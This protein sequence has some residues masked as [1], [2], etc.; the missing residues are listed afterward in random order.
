GVLG[1]GATTPFRKALEQF[2][3][4]V[5]F[6]ARVS[7]LVQLL[8]KLTSPGVPDIYQGT[9][10]WDYSLVDPDN[11]RPVDYELR[12][13][14][15]EEMNEQLAKHGQNPGAVIAALLEA[16]ADG[17]I[18]LYLTTRTLQ[19]RKQ[20]RALFERG[21]YVPVTVRGSKS[22][23]VCAYRRLLESDPNQ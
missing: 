15:L 21:G 18:K 20:R 12:K 5:G 14:A 10:L 8:F 6:Y 4:R 7:S 23:A 1:G 9:E 2:Q 19:L 13:K 11:R 16:S 3:K 17:R 22:E